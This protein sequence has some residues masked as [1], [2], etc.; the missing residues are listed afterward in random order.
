MAK[1]VSQ[2][3]SSLFSRLPQEPSPFWFCRRTGTPF[4]Y[5]LLPPKLS[6]SYRMPARSRAYM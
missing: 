4:Q 2:V 1:Q 6:T 3:F 5:Q